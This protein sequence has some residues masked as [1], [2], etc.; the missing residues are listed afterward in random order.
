[1][2]Q[3]QGLATISSAVARDLY[4]A[5]LEGTP[6]LLQ[7]FYRTVFDCCRK[8]DL[9]RDVM[10]LVLN[11][12]LSKDR[13]LAFY[14][15]QIYMGTNEGSQ[16]RG[17]EQAAASYLKKPL[18]QATSR[19]FIGLV[20]QIKAPNHYHPVKNPA[21]H[22]ERTRRIEALVSRKCKPDGWF[23]TT[24]EQCGPKP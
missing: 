4:H 16:V 6:A 14:V 17:L 3:G 5:K 22:L 21:A 1:M 23:D 8:V 9:G 18:A 15:S 20:A 19:E 12:R 7:R 13:Q 10:A 2:A 24:Y 11:A